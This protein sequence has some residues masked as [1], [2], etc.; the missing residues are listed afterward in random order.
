MHIF[1]MF[2][3]LTIYHCLNQCCGAG[4]FLAG[5]VLLISFLL[6]LWSLNALVRSLKSFIKG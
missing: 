6:R 1:Y 3:S 4:L 5:S 2:F